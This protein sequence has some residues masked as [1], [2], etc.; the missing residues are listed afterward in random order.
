MSDKLAAEIVN[1]A[2]AVDITDCTTAVIISNLF[3]GNFTDDI[4]FI[5]LK[6]N[7]SKDYIEELPD[8]EWII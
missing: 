4:T 5:I 1:V 7:N 2:V 6:R 8:N 3:I